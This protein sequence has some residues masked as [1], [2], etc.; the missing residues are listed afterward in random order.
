MG[1]LRSVDLEQ[2]R[3]SRRTL[4][5]AAGAAGLFSL[6]GS[7]LAAC[8]DDEDDDDVD[9]GDQPGIDPTAT[10][11]DTDDDDDDADD[12]DDDGDDTTIR[13]VLTEWAVDPS[14]TSVPAGDVTFEV[15]N[16]GTM[17]HDFVLIKTELAFDALNLTGDG[18]QVDEEGSGDVVISMDA[19]GP[20][21][22]DPDT[23]N[24]VPGHYV[25]LCNVA[26][27]YQ[28]GMRADFEVT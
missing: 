13:V 25:M 7:L 2:I 1:V 24:L 6:A 9:A 11:V 27:H 26:G 15:V 19:F 18:T 17:D 8:G 10:I 23:Q 12:G 22:P 14:A 20:G 5:K 21:E 3:L 28:L 4:L 16:A